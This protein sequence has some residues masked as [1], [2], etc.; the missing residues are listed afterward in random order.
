MMPILQT[1]LAWTQ[2]PW[3]RVAA[4]LVAFAAFSRGFE[5][6]NCAVTR[7]TEG[8]QRFFVPPDAWRS[9]YGAEELR[10]AIAPIDPSGRTLYALTQWTLDLAFPL[11]YLAALLLALRWVF[12]A[13]HRLRWLANTLPW[14]AAIADWLE[15]AALAWIVAR[16]D[17]GAAIG[18]V[19]GVLTFSKW[20]FLLAAIVL[21]AIGFVTLHA[22]RARRL[23][24]HLFFARIPLLLG[25]LVVGLAATGRRQTCDAPSAPPVGLPTVQNLLSADNEMQFFYAVYLAYIA[26]AV[27]VFSGTHLWRLAHKRIGIEKMG[28]DAQAA[29]EW[30]TRILFGLSGFGLALPLLLRLTMDGDGSPW[31][32]WCLGILA[33]VGTLLFVLVLRNLLLGRYAKR[34]NDTML[35]QLRESASARLEAP[36][37]RALHRVVGPGFDVCDAQ[38]QP[39]GTLFRGH[40]LAAAVALALAVGYVAGGRVLNPANALPNVLDV[41]PIA[42][43]ML[44]IAFVC[45]LFSSLTFLL[46]RIRVPVVL[47]FLLWVVFWGNLPTAWY[48]TQ[49]YFDVTFVPEGEGAPP[50]IDEAFRARAARAGPRPIVVVAAAGGGIQA[51]GWTAVV[52]EGLHRELGQAFT[53]SIYLLSATSGGS[54]GAYFFIEALRAETL[55]QEPP[56]ASTGPQAQRDKYVGFRITDEQLRQARASRGPRYIGQVPKAAQASSLEATAWGLVFPDLQRLATPFLVSANP[57]RTELDRAW[58]IEQAWHR[59]RSCMVTDTTVYHDDMERNP[60]CRQAL[61]MSPPPARLS[62][63]WAGARDGSLPGVI[64]N[65]TIIE[66]GEQFMAS[67]LD[68]RALDLA[69]DPDTAFALPGNWVLGGFDPAL[70]EHYPPREAARPRSRTDA[71]PPRLAKDGMRINRADPCDPPLHFIDMRAV[72]AA[73]LSATFPY[74]TPV[75]RAR[76]RRD[77]TDY[78]GGERYAD[79]DIGAA[80]AEAPAWHVG[81]GGYFDNPGSLAVIRWIEEIRR[82]QRNDEAIAVRDI[83][84]VQIT[85]FPARAERTLPSDGQGWQAALLGPLRAMLSVRTSSQLARSDLELSLLRGLFGERFQA[86]EFRPGPDPDRGDPPLSWELSSEDR[87]RLRRDWCDPRNV[88]I[89]DDL[90]TRF[91]NGRRAACESGQAPAS[92]QPDGGDRPPER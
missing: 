44:L 87:A 28:L 46:D 14:L 42:Y 68:L 91:F 86:V 60:D 21:A 58:A 10:R 34:V 50:A 39:T 69:R 65:G 75:A 84:F 89:V 90:A 23:L 41:P 73:R 15:N 32:G 82:L 70:C 38:G 36:V 79:T 2:R 66:D 11:L 52:L 54:V 9:L 1:V 47:A 18:R 16:A 92:E 24:Q 61:S 57:A 43:V 37:S 49:H 5:W 25:L 8:L 74:V 12:P 64:L 45:M 33:G 80:L 63:W 72:T 53:D 27:I 13:G 20:A 3:I 4:F 29:D 7:S 30:Q 40:A 35:R 17:F 55:A 31:V 26:C 76:I 71:S 48:D 19:A 81:D 83:L 51:A 77:D 22:A 85:P 67:S 6:R 88:A 62:D 56:R 59:W 78:E